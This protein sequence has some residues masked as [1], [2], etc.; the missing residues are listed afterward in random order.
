MKARMTREVRESLNDPDRCYAYAQ[1][2]K[3]E[4]LKHVKRK[5]AGPPQPRIYP[6]DEDSQPPSQD[7]A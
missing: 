1:R 4:Y 5:P 3:A 2:L 6:A 7:A